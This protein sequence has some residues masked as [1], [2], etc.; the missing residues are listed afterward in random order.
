MLQVRGGPD[1]RTA[2]P[3]VKLIINDMQQLKGFYGQKLAELPDPVT[4][5][6]VWFGMISACPSEWHALVV[7][8]VVCESPATEATSLP[9]SATCTI[10]HCKECLS[11]G[12]TRA[13][14]SQKALLSHQRAKHNQRSMINLFV[15]GSGVCPCCHVVFRNRKRVI[16]HLSETRTRAKQRYVTCR[17]RELA[18]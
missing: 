5:A 4:G 7:A 15:D 10:H 9:I 14:S 6:H 16:A 11:S 12:V 17:Q 2:L 3:W 1:K 13:F 18:G 8:Y